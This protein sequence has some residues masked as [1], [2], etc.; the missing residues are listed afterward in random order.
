MFEIDPSNPLSLAMI[1]GPKET[2]GEFPMAIA[3]SSKFKKG[4][5][6]PFTA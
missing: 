6:E 2:L 4:K 5:Y 1:G 3:Y